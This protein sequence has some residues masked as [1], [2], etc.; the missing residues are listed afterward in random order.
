M[1]QDI[2]KKQSSARLW[3]GQTAEGEI[4]VS[5]ETIDKI[6]YQIDFDKI[7]RNSPVPDILGVDKKDVRTVI[8]WIKNNRH[9]H[10]LPV[11]KCKLTFK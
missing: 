2:I 5:Y 6:L 7:L 11:P 10:E 3:K 8:D 1:P 9:K 4:G